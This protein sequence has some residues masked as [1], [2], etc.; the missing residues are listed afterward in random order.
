MTLL[1]KLLDDVL[2]TSELKVTAHLIYPKAST[3]AFS[4]HIAPINM[5][6]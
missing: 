2:M 3:D 1:L 4:R 6:N 5:T